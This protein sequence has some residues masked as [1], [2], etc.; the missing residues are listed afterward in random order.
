M[1]SG[2]LANG[3]DMRRSKLRVAQQ[4]WMVEHLSA[5]DGGMSADYRFVPASGDSG[6]G[7]S[8]LSV[9]VTAKLAHNPRKP[10]FRP[11]NGSRLVMAS[12]ATMPTPMA[13]PVNTPTIVARFQKRPR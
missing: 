5:K 8:R 12:N 3:F 13:I 9:V 1:P 2:E 4:S 7:V 11:K 10:A 6:P